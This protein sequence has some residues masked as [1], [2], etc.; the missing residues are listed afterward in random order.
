[1]PEVQAAVGTATLMG[2]RSFDPA[3]LSTPEG[4]KVELDTLMAFT[5]EQF[6][7][8]GFVHPQFMLYLQRDP[9]TGARADVQYVVIADDGNIAASLVTT[10]CVKC[11]AVAVAMIAETWMVKAGIE[12]CPKPGML[13]EDPRRAERL[14]VSFEHARATF[15]HTA[16]IERDASGKGTLKPWEPLPTPTRLGG[17]FTNMLAGIAARKPS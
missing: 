10:L 16:D 5:A 15:A 9:T 4:M 7:H 13:H 8:A 2:V 14:Y 1:M 17:R 11:E 12:D 3:A 6:L